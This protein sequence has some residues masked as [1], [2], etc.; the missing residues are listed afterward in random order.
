MPP[1]GALSARE[2]RIQ[3]ALFIL[4]SGFFDSINT[5]AQAFALPRSTLQARIKVKST[6]NST[7]IPPIRGGHN[8]KI[9]KPQEAVLC[10]WLERCARHRFLPRQDYIY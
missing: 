4:K 6:S 10:E 3:E 7:S 9:N 8:K 1:T 2:I 5:V